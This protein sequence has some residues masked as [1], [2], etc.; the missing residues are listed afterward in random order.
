MLQ[1]KKKILMHRLIWF[2]VFLVFLLLTVLFGTVCSET[3]IVTLVLVVPLGAGCT[4]VAFT[5]W[6]GAFLVNYKTYNLYGNAILVYAGF[7]HHYIKINGKIFDEHNTL[8]TFTPIVLSTT[9]W[10][11]SIQATISLTNRIS[12]KI[13]NVLASPIKK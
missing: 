10:I 5:F 4:I 2:G 1:E 9:L 6:I 11:N 13:N 8:I 3:D 7:Y 12:V